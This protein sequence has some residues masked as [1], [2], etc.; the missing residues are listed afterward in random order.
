MDNN[1]ITGAARE[2]RTRQTEAERIIWYKLRDKQLCGIKFRRQ[3]PIGNYIVDFVSFDKKLILEIDGSPHK[4]TLTKINDNRRTLWL[5]EQGFKVLRFW[6][7]DILNDIEDV[8]KKIIEFT[9]EGTHPHL[10]SPIEGEVITPRSS[11]W[12]DLP[13][14]GKSN[15]S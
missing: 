13:P 15:S 6:N 7:S 2:L 4:K 5:Q 10:A 9:K 14:Q 8:L 11:V 1:I 12:N 3:E